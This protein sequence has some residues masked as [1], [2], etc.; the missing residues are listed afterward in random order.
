MSSKISMLMVIKYLIKN[1]RKMF[2]VTLKY[3][4][5]GGEIIFL[6]IAINFILMKF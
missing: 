3:N 6:M 1:A 5:Q 2:T 4:S